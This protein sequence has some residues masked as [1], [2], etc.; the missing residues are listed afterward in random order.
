LSERK[1]RNQNLA[2]LREHAL[3]SRREAAVLVSTPQVANNL[4]HLDDI[5]RR[6][7]LQ[8]RLVTARP[9]RRLL[10]KGRTKHIENLAQTV[11]V[12][13]VTNTDKVDILRGDL[14]REITLS[15]VKLQ[16]NL[17]FTPDGSFLDLSDGCGPVMG[18]NDSLADLEKH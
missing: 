18:V 2:G 11:L 6:D 3:L 5:A 13:D 1:L 15:D 7:L 17:L 9:V 8:V 14:D 12:D 16:V 10:H 4:R